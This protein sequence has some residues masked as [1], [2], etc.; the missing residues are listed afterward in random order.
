MNKVHVDLKDRSY[1]ILINP[2]ILDDI[3]TIIEPLLKNRK[4]FII[5]DTNV[6]PLY[7]DKLINEIKKTELLSI[8]HFLIPAGEANKNLS[9]MEA[10]FNTLAEYEIERNSIIIA[11]GGGVVGDMAGFA[12]ASYMRGI[13]FIQIPTSLLAMVDSSVGGK[14]GVDLPAGKN[15]VGAFWQ[16]KLVVI[17][18]NVLNT[19]P[20]R[21][22][23][24]GM[25]ELVKHGIILD[26]NLFYEL[27]DNI[28]AILNLDLDVFTEI[29][30]RSCEIKAD[31]VRQ[32]ECEKGIRELL[33]FGHTFG[34]AIETVTGYDKYIHGEA[35]GLGMLI[36]AELSFKLGKID[37]E[38]VQRL[39][40]FF[41]KVGFPIR[42]SG[43]DIGK[44][45]DAMSKDKKAKSNQIKYII[46]E[47]IGKAVSITD[48]DKNIIFDSI[49]KFIV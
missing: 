9:T 29:I 31:V 2:N 40:L 22:V 30:T 24:G 44:V 42:V 5:S 21:E 36:A 41:D 27:E 45:I 37:E 12:A 10:I 46:I 13:D 16:P 19:L 33:N 1:D 35:V 3:S 6:F 32:D 38:T 48:V 28:D 17:D 8:A 14:T 23:V 7:G 20:D 25:A 39:R 34:H 26:E 43:V 11:L 4:C 49:S 18:P 47:E 15:L